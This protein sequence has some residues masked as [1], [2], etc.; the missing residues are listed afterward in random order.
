MATAADIIRRSLKLLG[1]LAAGETPSADD[2]AD[3]LVEL[4]ALLGTWANE[5]LLVHGTR[6][7]EY[8]LTG[9]LSPHTI[10]TGGTFNTT[11]PLRIDAAGIVRVG[12]TVETGIKKLTD[13]EYQAISEKA[14]LD[15]VP[16]RFWVEQT[17]PT[18]KLWFWP[19]PTTAATLVLYTWSRISA[20]SANDT[21]SLPDGYE[22][23]LAHALAIQIAPM[24]GVEPSP[25]VRDNASNAIAAIK[26]TNMPEVL[27]EL[28][29]GVL[30]MGVGGGGDAIVM[31][32][33]SG[34]DS[35]G[36]Y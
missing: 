8:T 16:T 5:R 36:L 10:G 34:F 9:N 19:V 6:R 17:Y 20:F 22:N 18:A 32:S 1:I 28:D 31:T 23:A 33:T 21:V 26:R 15:E 30:P 25:T 27:M 3:G 12:E 4:N 24:Y 13:A 11:R 29:A 7:A 35:G 14:Q 2:Q